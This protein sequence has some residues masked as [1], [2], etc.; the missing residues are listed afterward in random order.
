M[1]IPLNGRVLEVA[2]CDNH[3]ESCQSCLTVDIPEYC[4][5]HE[6]QYYQSKA[7]GRLVLARSIMR[8]SRC[9]RTYL[10]IPLE[11]QD[12]SIDHFIRKLRKLVQAC[13]EG[14]D[15]FNKQRHLLREVFRVQIRC[16]YWRPD[17]RRRLR[18]PLH[19]QRRVVQLGGGVL[20][21]DLPREQMRGI[22]V[23]QVEDLSDPLSKV[24]SG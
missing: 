6:A 21:V 19:P 3:H 7:L 2:W 9:P 16:D 5:R 22:L 13:E 10:Q 23:K 14:R 1:K 8:G 24:V 11:N 20:M 17:V 4:R 15:V 18:F 12:G